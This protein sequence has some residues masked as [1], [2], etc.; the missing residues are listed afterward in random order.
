[1]ATV[2]LVE[3]PKEE[4]RKLS[5]IF[6]ANFPTKIIASLHS[7]RLHSFLFNNPEA[8]I[9]VVNLGL[10]KDIDLNIKRFCKNKFPKATT[11]CLG[12]GDSFFSLNSYGENIDSPFYSIK[13]SENIEDIL[14]FVKKIF[15][16]ACVLR[17][18]KLTHL[19]Y[20][21]IVYNPIE[22]SYRVIPYEEFHLLAKKEASLL[23][24][25]MKSPNI[26]L[27]RKKI[28]D[29]IWQGKNI[30]SRVIDVQVSKLRKKLSETEVVIES[31]YGG[32]YIMR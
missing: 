27:S 25:F 17:Y 30:S 11:L 1:M 19:E 13:E 26:C 18:S 20:R 10:T 6:L 12:E 29:A 23:Q 14:C 31:I 7:L 21:D 9:L 3:N 22:Q 5:S 32:G 16:R 2:W 24:M 28:Q 8:D 15:S 4:R